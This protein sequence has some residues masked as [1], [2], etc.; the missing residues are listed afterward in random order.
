M[1]CTHPIRYNN[2]ELVTLPRVTTETGW[3]TSG[4]KTPLSM[5]AQGR[6]FLCLYLSQFAQ[7]FAHTFVYMLRDD[8]GQGY[9]GF[10]HTNYTMKPSGEMM[11]RLT[12]V[13]ADTGSETDLTALSAGLDYT[14]A[15]QP[16]TM[17]DKLFVKSSG[18]F[19]L[20]VWSERAGGAADAVE[21][22]LGAVYSTVKVYDPTSSARPRTFSN[23]RKV[24][25][26]FNGFHAVVVE[27]RP[28]D[29]LL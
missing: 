24:P 28:A 25:L 16:E 6:L 5:E 11:H 1:P 18:V 14:I 23:V 26:A 20:A 22:D 10:I 7:G 17:H 21:V 9:W 3:V 19:E 8:P 13:L 29:L 2:V 12:T 15:A 4:G 27:V